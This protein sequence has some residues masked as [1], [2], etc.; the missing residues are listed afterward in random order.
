MLPISQ[1]NKIKGA[2]HSGNCSRDKDVLMN[3]A[4]SWAP[5]YKVG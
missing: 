4:L 5:T 2:K 1:S 3:V